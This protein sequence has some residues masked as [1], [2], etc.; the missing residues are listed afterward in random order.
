[1]ADSQAPKSPTLIGRMCKL[2][3]QRRVSENV[4]KAWLYWARSLLLFH[5]MKDVETLTADDVEAFLEHLAGHHQASPASLHQAALASEF[6]LVQVQQRQVDG[7]QNLVVRTRQ[8]AGP[9]IL[10]PQ[11]IQRILGCLSGPYWLIGSLVYGAG[12]RLME[13]VR[14]RIRDIGADRILVRDANG[15]FRRETVLPERVRDPLKVHLEDLKIIHIREL[16]E[17]Y[18]SVQLPA[19]LRASGSLQRSWAWQFVFPGS[20]VTEV[21]AREKVSLKAHLPE[22]IAHQAIA[23]AAREAGLEQKVSGSTLRNSFAAHLVSRGVA[24]GDVERLLGI[25]ADED[26]MAARP[27]TVASAASPIDRLAAH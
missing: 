5:E 14:L 9:V 12:L 16:A 3:D 17:G 24:V 20:Y 1:M 6:L 11:E 26:L 7:L 2:L 19:G 23:T 10:S 13:C 15:R 4:Q 21:S 18:G 22:P 27:D 8:G 25:R